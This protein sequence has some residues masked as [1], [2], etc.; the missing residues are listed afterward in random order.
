MWRAGCKRH[1]VFVRQRNGTQAGFTLVELLAVMMVATLTIGAISALYRSPSP[2][3]QVK[4]LANLTASRLRDLR[5]SAMAARTERVATIDTAKRLLRFNDGRAPLKL[6]RVV[7]VTVT[8]AD[9]EVI[10]PSAANIRF[11]PNGSS[12]GATVAFRSKGQ[13]Y[14]VRVNWLTGR[15]STTALR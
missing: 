13:G 10:A 6:D 1:A 2:G 15:V 4:T 9:D 14:E 11:Y 3:A 7:G 8:A 12:S 5:A